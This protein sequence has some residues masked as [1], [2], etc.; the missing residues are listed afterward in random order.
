MSSF[1]PYLCKVS[2][3][4]FIILQ[5]EW[6]MAQECDH[7]ERLPCITSSKYPHG[8][9]NLV[10][11]QEMIPNYMPNLVMTLE[12]PC[13]A[14]PLKTMLMPTPSLR[15]CEE[16]CSY[17]CRKG[18]IE[19]V[20][21]PASSFVHQRL[22]YSSYRPAQLKPSIISSTSVHS[23]CPNKNHS[24]AAQPL[25]QKHTKNASLPKFVISSNE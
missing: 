11:E 2:S 5:S 7:M 25:A 3:L 18:I 16:N 14:I 17:G 9:L 8:S 23:R 15:D 20:S 21:F 12:L 4:E 19:Y 1:K 10:F 13:L 24:L 22:L 6:P